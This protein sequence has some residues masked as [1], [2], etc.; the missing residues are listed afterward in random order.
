MSKWFILKVLMFYI[1]QLGEMQMDIIKF[2]WSKVQIIYFDAY[3]WLLHRG[4]C[5]KIIVKKVET[6]EEN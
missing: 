2:N 3:L 4:L 1:L 6:S 5:R